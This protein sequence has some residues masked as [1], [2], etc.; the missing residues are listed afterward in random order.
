MHPCIYYAQAVS[1][2]IRC[3]HCTYVRVYNELDAKIFSH[4]RIFSP[5]RKKWCLQWNINAL[6]VKDISLVRD[7]LSL[8]KERAHPLMLK[9]LLMRP[10]L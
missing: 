1:A 7:T 8:A 2:G 4:K 6:V 10:I 3:R 5:Q 9:L